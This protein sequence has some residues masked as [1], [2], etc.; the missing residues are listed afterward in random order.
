MLFMCLKCLKE[1]SAEGYYQ[2][3]WSKVYTLYVQLVLHIPITVQRHA[4]K[5]YCFTVLGASRVYRSY[6]ERVCVC[7]LNIC[8]MAYYIYIK[9]WVWHVYFFK[10]IAEKTFKKRFI[11]TVATACC[12]IT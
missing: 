1:G 2:A 4:A 10:D 12:I 8:A 11:Y 9:K 5:T 7:F 6:K 3:C